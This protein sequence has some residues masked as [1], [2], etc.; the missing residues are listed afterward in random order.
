MNNYLLID[1][2]ILISAID[3]DSKFLKNAIKLILDSSFELCTTC[4]NTSEF[5]AVLTRSREVDINGVE[6]LEILESLL[7]NF[8][9]LYPSEK[10][11]RKFV[12]LIPNYRPRG[13]WIYG[14]MILR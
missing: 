7:L 5:L 2:N 4:K 1:T 12:E 14:Y 13:L 10:S 3:S 6:A 11:F 9:V 8:G